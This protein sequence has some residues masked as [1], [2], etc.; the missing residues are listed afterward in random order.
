MAPHR[1]VA[2]PI[3]VRPD[4]PPEVA[5]RSPSA[6]SRSPSAI[7]ACST[8][9]AICVENAVDFAETKVE[10]EARWSKDEVRIVIADDG[11][12]FPPYVLEQLGE[13]FVTTR[14]GADATAGGARRAYRHGAR[15]LHR[16]DAARAV[17]RQARAR[18]PA[19]AGGRRRGHRALAAG[20]IR[21]A[22][23]KKPQ[24]KGPSRSALARAR[25]R[26]PTSSPLRAVVAGH[27]GADSLA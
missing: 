10:V 16:Q 18:Q 6:A 22:C 9:S 5:P 14:P 25:A 13:P 11:A 8:G 2:V 17:G 27:I 24:F 4:P 19:A 1:L 3:E 23:P 20:E 7:R 12:G 26:F 15:L 21:A